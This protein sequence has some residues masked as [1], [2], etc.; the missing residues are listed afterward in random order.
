MRA[1]GLPAVA[2]LSALAAAAAGACGSN[3][4]S[5][6]PPG[7]QGG[8][9]AGADT[10]APLMEAG[11]ADAAPAQDGGIDAPTDGPAGVVDASDGGRDFSN[12]PGKFFGSSRC[13]QSGL[14]L[15]DGFETGT[16]DTTTWSASGTMPVVDGVQHARGS[17]AL[18]ITQH[19]NGLS[20]IKETKTFPEP[21]NTY[22]GRAFVYFNQLPAAP[23]T[24]AH[25]TFIAAS[26][27]GASGEI[28]V[29]G[30]L[31]NGRNLFGVGTDTGTNPNGSGDWT[32]SDNDPSGM[33]KAVPL[34]QWACIEW[35]H[36]GDTNETRFYWDAVEHPSL[37]TSATMHGGN[38]NPYI[39]PQFTNAWIGWQEYQSS[40]ETFEM[41]VDEVAIDPSRI[42]CVL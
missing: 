42:G 21:K 17:K 19:G 20:Y 39:L 30:Q 38:S 29:S 1:L 12:D 9:E 31:Q 27:T 35:M 22:W 23:M 37:Y 7:G 8:Q 3:G 2:L 32:N 6:N 16:L 15:C 25:W 18:H 26:G 14:Q 5:S 34:Q 11:A 24:Y 36:K 40:T 10:G 28:R 4:G 13:A 33:P 41:W